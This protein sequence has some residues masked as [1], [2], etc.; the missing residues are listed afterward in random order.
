MSKRRTIVS[1]SSGT[2][3]IM[4][5]IF[6]MAFVFLVIGIIE[7]TRYHLLYSRINQALDVTAVSVATSHAGYSPHQLSQIALQYFTENYPK[8]YLGSSIKGIEVIEV[9]S[10]QLHFSVRV[11]VP[12]I[13]LE[14]L[15]S[16]KDSIETTVTVRSSK[17]F[18]GVEILQ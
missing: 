10:D 11:S 8:Q 1:D 4:V 15:N 18:G 17:G 9:A 3:I 12:S 2:V 13:F 6:L 14:F 16:G 5:A 7:L